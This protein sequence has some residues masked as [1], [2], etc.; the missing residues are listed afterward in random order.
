MDMKKNLFRKCLSLLAALSCGLT[1]FSFAETSPENKYYF[2]PQGLVVVTRPNG[3]SLLQCYNDQAQ[4]VEFFATDDSFHYFYHYN[5]TG[6][7]DIVQDLTNNLLIF[8]NF[9]D[10]G[11]LVKESIDGLEI[12]YEYDER[13]NRIRMTLPDSSS[14]G[15]QYDDNFLRE[16]QRITPSGDILYSHKYAEISEAGNPLEMTMIGECGALK[17]SYTANGL[18][19]SINSS[20]WNEIISRDEKQ[21]EK[22]LKAIQTECCF[23]KNLELYTYDDAEQ[24]VNE[25]GLFNT[26]ISYDSN[27]NRLSKNEALYEIQ[28]INQYAS[29]IDGEDYTL[30]HYDLNGNLSAKLQDN[31]WTLYKYDGLDRLISVEKEK[32]SLVCF[33]YDAF[34]RRMTKTVFTWDCEY[35]QWLL[36]SHYR[37]I[38][39]DAREIGSINT[40]NG[41]TEIRILGIGYGAEIGA[42]IALELDGYTFAPIHNHRGDICCLVDMITGTPV[43]YYQYSAFG[44]SRIFSD[45]G[46]VL[47]ESAVQNPWMFSSKRLDKETGLVY[48][49]KRYLDTD[50]GRWLTKDP[51]GSFDGNNPYAFIR[52]NPLT[53]IDAY[54]LFSWPTIWESACTIKNAISDYLKTAKEFLSDTRSELG[55]AEYVKEEYESFAKALLGEGFLQFAGFYKDTLRYGSSSHEET[56]DKVRITVINGI[57]NMSNHLE[58]VVETISEAHGGAKIHYVFNPTKGWSRDLLNS[59]MSK[60][61]YVSPQAQLLADSWRALIEEMGGVDGGGEIIHYAHS[62]GATDSFVAMGL[63]T[64]EE[65]K[66]IHMIT[67]GSPSLNPL[68]T[69][70][71]SVTHYV[72]KRDGV[73]ML[74]PYWYFG[75]L[76]TDNYPNIHFLGSFMGIPFIDHTLYTDSYNSLIEDLGKEFLEKYPVEKEP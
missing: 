19:E 45:L 21:P 66:M 46:Q 12:S 29:R 33:S 40:L 20:V 31:L 15:Y 67:L 8:R 38:Y 68:D 54:G 11:R 62:V 14:V 30:F 65:S 36:Q 51:L 72:S 22:L 27:G 58:D 48:F 42:S 2:L 47:N 73:S 3:T 6:M 4:L 10:A 75:A 43:E 50:T 34:F 9:D 13:G 28:N 35:S 24:V 16:I 74:D 57:L 76:L 56:H 5:E 60:L 63:L 61:G 69:G 70:F 32:T 1:S 44:E 52:N 53:Q 59:A 71:A 25:E 49:G 39:D 26:L 41:Q 37:Y 17:F 18:L 7:L 55:L 23:G 64:P